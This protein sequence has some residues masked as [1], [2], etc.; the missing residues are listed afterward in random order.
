[1]TK[2]Q[3]LIHALAIALA[4]LII[5]SIF[6]SIIGAVGHLFGWAGSDDLLADSKTYEVSDA[7]TSL[8]I[9]IRSAD[10]T[11]R[12]G[13]VFSVESNL[14]HLTV[15]EDGDKLILR[16]QKRFGATDGSGKL[17]LTIPTDAV[18]ER[19][20]LETGACR[21]H[22][23]ALTANYVT[24]SLGAGESVFDSLTALTEA[25]IDG[26]A[27][28]L[29]VSDGT[30]HNLDLDM[31]VGQLDLT[32]AILGDS[33]LDMGVGESNLTLLGDKDV[34]TVRAD[35]GIGE[36]TIDG[37]KRSEWQGSGEHTV[38][39]DGGIGAIHIAFGGE[40]NV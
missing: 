21:L 1:M 22:V 17:I 16:E 5:I 8:D 13:E 6:G 12:Q 23:K 24:I 7:I 32:A 2:Q 35:K 25:D 36:I 4:V 26:G 11:V 28:R 38:E 3:K 33:E 40:P 29:T 30:L 34:Y 20:T 39:I 14:K 31:G 10:L 18:L 37:E 9:K 27:G 15:R 19:V